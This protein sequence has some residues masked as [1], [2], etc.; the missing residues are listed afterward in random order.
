MRF[1]RWL[2]LILLH[3]NVV[4]RQCY[5]CGYRWDEHYTNEYDVEFAENPVDCPSCGILAGWKRSD[6]G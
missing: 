4:H 5:F 1:F 6:H 3:P 2:G